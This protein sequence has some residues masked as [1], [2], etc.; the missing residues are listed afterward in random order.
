MQTLYIISINY[1]SG[2]Y[3]RIYLIIILH[4][5]L[6]KNKFISILFVVSIVFAPTKED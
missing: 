4:L 6:V 5:W 1:T 3:N 2:Y